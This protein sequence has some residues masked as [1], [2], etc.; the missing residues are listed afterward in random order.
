[1]KKIIV[2][3]KVY[4]VG[5]CLNCG[6]DKIKHCKANDPWSDEHWICTECDSTYAIFNKDIAICN[7]DIFHK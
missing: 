1:M 3:K 7:E 4:E 5:P 6:E 2:K